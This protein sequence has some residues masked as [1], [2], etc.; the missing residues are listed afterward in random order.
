MKF[1]LENKLMFKCGLMPSY[2]TN[3]TKGSRVIDFKGYELPKNS[4]FPDKDELDKNNV[5][6]LYNFSSTGVNTPGQEKVI[7]AENNFSLSVLLAPSFQMPIGFKWGLDFGLAYSLG[8]SDMFKHI[9]ASDNFLGRGQDESRSIIQDYLPSSSHS[10]LQI[11]AG[12][13]YNLK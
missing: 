5:G 4:N 12:I 9:P 2:L 8:I 10:Q 11:R 7:T 3:V 6:E 1:G 13:F